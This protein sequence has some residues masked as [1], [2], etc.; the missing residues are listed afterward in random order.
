MA[1]PYT[2]I[3]GDGGPYQVARRF[4][5]TLSELFG[6]NSDV[7]SAQ[8][9]ETKWRPGLVVHI[10]FRVAPEVL[11]GKYAWDFAGNGIQLTKLVAQKLAERP[12]W[13]AGHFSALAVFEHYFNMEFRAWQFARGRH[14][15]DNLLFADASGMHPPPLY[16]PFPQPRA[17]P[18]A[19]VVPSS[20]SPDSP[21]PP[22]VNLVTP[23]FTTAELAAYVLK[24]QRIKNSLRGLIESR[25]HAIE[26]AAQTLAVIRTA[27]GY[28]DMQ[29]DELPSLPN[30]SNTHPVFSRKARLGKVQRAA[31]ALLDVAVDR[32]N[33]MMPELSKPIDEWMSKDAAE[34]VALQADP[35]YSELFLACHKPG[36]PLALEVGREFMRKEFEETLELA[37]KTPQQPAI[38][39]LMEQAFRGQGPPSPLAIIATLASGKTMTFGNLPGPNSLCLAMARLSAF[40]ALALANHS[41]DAER[42]ITQ[43]VNKLTQSLHFKPHEASRFREHVEGIR[44][45]GLHN[46]TEHRI[47]PS[48]KAAASMIDEKFT[49]FQNN[50][51]L[52]VALTVL[53]IIQLVQVCRAMPDHDDRKLKDYL[54]FGSSAF[55]TGTATFAT[56]TRWGRQVDV[57]AIK[58]LMGAFDELV[59]ASNV[60]V[61]RVFA[62]IAVVQGTISIFEG[63]EEHDM[64]KLVVG[65]V[66]VAS[67]VLIIAGAAN[68]IPGAQPVGVVLGAIATAIAMKDTIADALRSEP[69]RMMMRYARWLQVTKSRWHS[70]QTI[71][72]EIGFVA[73]VAALVEAVNEAGSVTADGFYVFPVRDGSDPGLRRL[74]LLDRLKHLQIKGAAAEELVHSL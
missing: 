45:E 67:G 2:V 9:F 20:C 7:V 72:E 38:D 4:G 11:H 5:V 35:K 46:Q 8:N 24:L 12:Y 14:G 36:H 23:A 31:K 57:K 28:A 70:S 60:F 58:A 47:S 19:A 41:A 3:D 22:C 59:E 40:S 49:T 13:N 16:L 50:T 15:P 55:Q 18:P 34:F 74:M 65:G 62:V 29:V 10:P 71:A 44:K 66:T 25:E 69:A 26:D 64:T 33:P 53:D 42:A 1:F 52:N 30:D 17:L 51:L 56:V 21:K 27:K 39:A 37:Y 73:Q 43:V 48:Y 6:A 68:G 32:L 63:F 61:T 54:A